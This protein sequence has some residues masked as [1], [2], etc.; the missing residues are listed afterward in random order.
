MKGI[1]LAILA[2]VSATLAIARVLSTL[3]GGGRKAAPFSVGHFLA[4]CLDDPAH[5]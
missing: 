1:L 5:E 4:A 3:K 2:V